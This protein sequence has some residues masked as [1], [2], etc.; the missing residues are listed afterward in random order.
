VVLPDGAQ[1]RFLEIGQLQAPPDILQISAAVTSFSGQALNWVKH[2]S[3]AISDF[4]TEPIF[5]SCHCARFLVCAPSRLPPPPPRSPIS[6]VSLPVSGS[7]S[8]KF[9]LSLQ[10]GLV[11]LRS[12]RFCLLSPFEPEATSRSAPLFP[13]PFFFALPD[14][15][16][17]V[18]GLAAL[19]RAP[20]SELL[21]IPL[22]I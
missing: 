5:S 19:S 21:P 7:S 18:V 8:C 16:R 3:L 9:T 6:R 2:R 1:R 4:L 20:S 11:L 17:V 12:S 13:L 15:V 14:F 10:P 22:I